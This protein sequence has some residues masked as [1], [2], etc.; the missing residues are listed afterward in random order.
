MI[1]SINTMEKIYDNENLFFFLY[2]HSSQATYTNDLL[3]E[4]H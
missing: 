3:S 4:I 2:F 1:N